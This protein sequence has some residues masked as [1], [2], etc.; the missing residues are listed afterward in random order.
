[1]PKHE[2]PH[3]RNTPSKRQ[4]SITSLN[5]SPISTLK[6]ASDSASGQISLRS[7]SN[8]TTTSLHSE[9]ALELC[10]DSSS[11]GIFSSSLNLSLSAPSVTASDS[12]HSLPTTTPY[13]TLGETGLATPPAT[14][15]F[16]PGSSIVDLSQHNVA[17]E[18]ST[19]SIAHDTLTEAFP[20]FKSGTVIIRCNLVTPPKQWQLH[21]DI[22]AQHS[23]W[24]RQVM[25]QSA[26]RKTDLCEWLFFLLEEH[27]GQVALVLQEAIP[28]DRRLDDNESKVITVE[29][30]EVSDTTTGAMPVPP[31]S[32]PADPS[33]SP[34]SPTTRQ[35]H[36]ATVDLYNQIFASF[37][38]IPIA[39]TTSFP[40][41]LS[42]CESLLKLYSILCCTSLLLP[43]LTT[44]LLAHHHSLFTAIAH[45]PA[46]YLLLALSLHNTTIF[47]GS[48][49]HIIGAHPSWPWPTRRALLPQTI[50]DL[51]TRK[52]DDLERMC[53]ETERELLLLTIETQNDGPVEP[54]D[55]THF[56][57][58][59]VVQMFRDTLARE[60]H[61]LD[62]LRDRTLK[63]GTVYR[64]IWRGGDAY[65]PVGE[66][67]RVMARVMPSAVGA[68]DE[69]LGL[70]KGCARDV[71]GDVARNEAEVDVETEKVGWVTCVRIGR[72]DVPWENEE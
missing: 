37:Y 32:E 1:M 61:A 5:A 54:H 33:P 53:V 43:S 11:E 35:P 39:S 72:E 18:I 46:R 2:R 24:F 4:N 71:V 3:S 51:V 23:T 56:D 63:R 21:A 66:M 55:H 52:S 48:L 17:S 16:P 30:K 9:P 6:S 19:H 22:L 59:F 12:P 15:Q 62:V 13:S 60:L 26:Q 14:P 68:L 70:L 67:R 8:I 10:A 40:Q 42:T 44:A 29:H 38:S 20:I 58:W 49:T 41:T 34:A 57:T 7:Q 65:M 28:S 31:S 36:A 64:K 50:R 47:T 27:D 25:M 69:D 45:D